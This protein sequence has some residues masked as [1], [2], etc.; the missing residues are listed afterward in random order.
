MKKLFGLLF[1]LALLPSLPGCGGSDGPANV[2]ES[3][4][5]AAIDAY[6]AAIAADQAAMNADPPADL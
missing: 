1:V 2:V 6:D 4:D 3:A 5:Q